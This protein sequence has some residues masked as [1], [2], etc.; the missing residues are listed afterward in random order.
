M[1]FYISKLIFLS[2]RIDDL[3]NENNELKEAVKE[4]KDAAEDLQQK[5]DSM[6]AVFAEQKSR[7]G[8]ES[9]ESDGSGASGGW[10]NVGNDLDLDGEMASDKK[11]YDETV[12]SGKPSP[13]NATKTEQT[14]G[15]MWSTDTIK[16]LAKA[17]ADL[18]RIEGERDQL[19]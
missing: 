4:H 10:S 19:R 13:T 16:D 5:Y 15:D 11:D 8:E 7:N 3:V 1:C 6:I 2:Y 12:E 17:K 18:R 14:K 9:T